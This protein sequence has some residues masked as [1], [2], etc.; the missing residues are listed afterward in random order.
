MA[1]HMETT[2]HPTQHNKKKYH[3]VDKYFFKNKRRIGTKPIENR[4]HATY[5]Q[6]PNGKG[7]TPPC[8]QSVVSN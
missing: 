5:A 3:K 4:T 7:R 6:V 2:N 1:Q 8:M